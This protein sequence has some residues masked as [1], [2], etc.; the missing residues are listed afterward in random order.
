MEPKQWSVTTI[1]CEET[2]D[3]VLSYYP[4]YLTLNTVF[5]TVSKS[6]S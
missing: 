2:N 3:F 1:I 6:Q 5:N 4:D